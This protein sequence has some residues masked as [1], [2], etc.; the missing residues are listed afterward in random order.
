MASGILQIVLIYTNSSCSYFLPAVENNNSKLCDITNQR[1]Y[2][3]HLV[4]C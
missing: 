3:T 4:H 1:H 2:L